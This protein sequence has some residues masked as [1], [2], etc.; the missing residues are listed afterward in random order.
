MHIRT[1]ISRLVLTAVAAMLTLYLPN[2]AAAQT[3]PQF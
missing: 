3:D 1:N 2:R